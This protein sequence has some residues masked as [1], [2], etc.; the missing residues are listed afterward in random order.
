[1]PY[2]GIT[3]NNE[4]K[5]DFDLIENDIKEIND[6]L[7]KTYRAVLKLDESVW[8]AKE[9]D[10]IDQEFVP[11]LKKFAEKYANYLMARLNF[12]KDAVSKYEEL[13]QERS[14]LED[15]DVL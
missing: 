12:A 4:V 1:M 2:N 11:Y 7:E 5:S 10:K 8:K 13:D 3:I 14:K 9:K 15:I 6:I